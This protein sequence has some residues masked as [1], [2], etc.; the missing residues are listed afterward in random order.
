M[1]YAHVFLNTS[2]KSMY[3][4]RK[5][6]LERTQ[7]R[8]Q[9]EDSKSKRSSKRRLAGVVSTEDFNQH[10]VSCVSKLLSTFDKVICFSH[11]FTIIIDKEPHT[12]LCKGN[13]VCY[14]DAENGHQ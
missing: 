1:H 13:S 4:S 2:I 9:T 10:V 12:I 5:K 7:K 8:Q 6:S 14:T 3:D 11:T